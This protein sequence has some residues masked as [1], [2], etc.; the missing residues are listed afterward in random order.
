MKSVARSLDL[1]E[2]EKS[3]RQAILEVNEEINNLTRKQENLASDQVNL[4]TKIE[5]KRGDLE[6]HQNRLKQQQS[7]R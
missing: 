4:E 5:K 7:V 1:D 6:R 2:I 3:I